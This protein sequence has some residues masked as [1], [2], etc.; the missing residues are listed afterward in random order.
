MTFTLLKNFEVAIEVDNF[1]NFFFFIFRLL[2]WFKFYRVTNF[3]STS[4]AAPKLLKNI[5]KKKKKKCCEVGPWR[6]HKLRLFSP[7][8]THSFFMSIR[9]E[10]SASYYVLSRSI[11]TPTSL[12]RLFMNPEFCQCALRRSCQLQLF[13]YLQQTA[14][15]CCISF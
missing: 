13:S 15:F 11:V 6:P 7:L 10:F 3:Q 2:L 1:Y 9:I 4:P 5:S 12:A 14:C 8:L